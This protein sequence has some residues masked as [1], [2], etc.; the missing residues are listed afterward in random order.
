MLGI[1]SQAATND[2]SV[3]THAGVVNV[4]DSKWGFA[5]FPAPGDT[6]KHLLSE[7]TDPELLEDNE[8]DAGDKA[9][10]KSTPQP[11]HLKDF[12]MPDK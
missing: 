11:I 3:N 12:W 9:D 6:K 1:F 2:Q 4:A 8:K 10:T 5:E 7:L